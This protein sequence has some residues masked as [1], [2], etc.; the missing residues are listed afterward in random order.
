MGTARSCQRPERRDALNHPTPIW[1]SRFQAVQRGEQ[2]VMH[3]VARQADQAEPL[4]EGDEIVMVSHPN[5]P[6]GLAA[7]VVSA[8]H[9]RLHDVMD[10][11]VPLLGCDKQ[12]YVESWDKTNPDDLYSS[13]PEVV[14]IVFRLGHASV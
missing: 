4:V 11:D 6:R 7:T 5:M 1:C 2:T 10:E 14:R 12:A 13:N 3:L 9:Y 8:A